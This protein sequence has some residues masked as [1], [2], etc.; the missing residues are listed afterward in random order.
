[1]PDEK[2]T[3]APLST[4]NEENTITEQNAPEKK[5]MV[6]AGDTVTLQL[7]YPINQAGQVIS[8][9]TLRK[10]R[11]GEL[12][13]L[14]LTEVAAVNTDA[15]ITLLPRISTP[16]IHKQT[17]MMIDPADLL[18]IGASIVGFFSGKKQREE[19]IAQM[20]ASQ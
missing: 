9:V 13:G 10:P 7:E 8:E 19:M 15:I 18:S 4:A 14:A 1:M 17:A 6:F 2:M 16:I 20:E 3:V 12:R 5:K 11:A